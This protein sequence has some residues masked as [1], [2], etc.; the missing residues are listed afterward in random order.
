MPKI[1]GFFIAVLLLFLVSI[2][3]P[4]ATQP[5]SV[6]TEHRFDT[7]RAM[8]HL[9]VLLGDE[10]PHPVDSDSNDR[11]RERLIGLIR[12]LGFSPLTTDEEF[13]SPGWGGLSCARVQ[14][15]MFWIGQPGPNAILLASHYD[16]VPAGPGAADDGAGVAA[17]LEIASNLQQQTLSRPVLV[18]ITDGEEAGLIGAAAFVQNHPSAK[19]IA[20]VVSMEARG[21]RGPA[22][23]FETSVPNGRDIAVLDSD[24]KV[25]VAN[26]LTADVYAAMPN[27]TDVTE[28]LKLGVDAGNYAIN[29]GHAFYHTPR[30]NLAMLDQR[31]LFHMGASALAAM[32]ALLRQS[33]NEAEQQWLYTDIFGWFVLALPQF[34]SAP[35]F[36]LAVVSLVLVASKAG[37]SP[38]LRQALLPLVALVMGIGL[39]AGLTYALGVLRGQSEYSAAY[40]MALRAT[41]IAGSLLGA[42]LALRWLVGSRPIGG[43]FLVTWAWLLLLLGAISWFFPGAAILIVPSLFP[44]IGALLSSLFHHQRVARV[45]YATAAL[46]FFA[47]TFAGTH[48]FE[49]SLS[50]EATAPVTALTVFYLLLMAPFFPGPLD[51]QWT[52]P[53]SPA[54]AFALI[55][56]VA[57]AVTLMVPSHSIDAPKGLSIYHRLGEQPGE[58]V[59]NVAGTEPVPEEMQQIAEFELGPVPFATEP[60][61]RAPAPAFATE[62]LAVTVQEY[63]EE[64]GLAT[65]RI[66]IEGPDSDRLIVRAVEGGDPI[67][68]VDR[69]GM[70][71][72]SANAQYLACYGRSCRSLQVVV[73][74]PIGEAPIL[75]VLGLRFG[76]G[77]ESDGLLSA[78]PDW[79]LPRQ[80]G[81]L[82]IVTARLPL[83]SPRL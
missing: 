78:R 76:L 53:K 33:G 28:Y 22:I 10:Q 68:Y 75:E 35:L 23:M 70:N 19:N 74:H 83:S 79:A 55:V 71:N 37:Y 73:G 5:P 16:S 51:S 31:S 36:L 60:G 1:T 13:C 72:Q 59:W 2:F 49:V 58:A 80:A 54:T 32:E 69:A 14:N 43:L 30:D 41:Q 4:L 64:D 45:L 57:V 61:Q 29:D 26:S 47:C 66:G 40:P 77:R 44:L 62:G 46:V 63:L 56:I 3:R 81:D 42:L 39:A 12:A 15:V 11:V 9:E 8:S 7:A 17:S 18:L 67:S 21:V 52:L 34:L 65:Y 48:M 25:A 38:G 20:A 6:D 24:V 27:G 50:L 82:R